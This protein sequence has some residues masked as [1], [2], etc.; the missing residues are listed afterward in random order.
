MTVTV[1]GYWR[2]ISSWRFLLAVAILFAVDLRFEHTLVGERAAL[3]GIRYCERAR[4]GC[5][6]R[7]DQHHRNHPTGCGAVLRRTPTDST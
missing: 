3:G 1:R 4:E 6:G 5:D 7:P 2:H